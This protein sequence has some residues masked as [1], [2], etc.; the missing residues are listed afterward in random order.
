M[1]PY[2]LLEPSCLP[3]PYHLPEPY[4]LP[5]TTLQ[6]K[7]SPVP[8]SSLVSWFVPVVVVFLDQCGDVG[9]GTTYRRDL[10]QKSLYRTTNDKL[11]KIVLGR[12][13]ARKDTGLLGGQG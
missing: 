7:Y 5:E 4:R 8:R 2:L 1:P 9:E 10:P 13:V 6:K 3:E 11:L 12:N